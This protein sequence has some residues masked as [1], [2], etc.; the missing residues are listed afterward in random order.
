MKRIIAVFAFVLLVTPS[1]FAQTTDPL[2]Y[3]HPPAP[4]FVGA[5]SWHGHDY[6]LRN[7]LKEIDLSREQKAEIQYLLCSRDMVER[8][9]AIWRTLTPSQRHQL[10][11]ILE[12]WPGVI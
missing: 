12:S 3:V 2:N 6:R 7:A 4:H 8:D 1:V 10:D 11:E 9:E 5:E